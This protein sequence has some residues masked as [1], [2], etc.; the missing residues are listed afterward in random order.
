MLIP[1]GF[2]SYST[3]DDESSRGKLSQLRALLAGELQQHLGRAFKVNIFQD[4]AAIPPGRDWARQ[5]DE[6][7]EA[8]SFLI[9]IVTP[10]FLQSEWCCKE[11]EAFRHREER[12]GASGLIFPIHYIDTDHI[13]ATDPHECHD[14]SALEFLRARQW[15]DF[16]RLRLRHPDSED[17]ALRLEGLAQGIR[18][19]LR[20]P[21]A[22][23]TPSLPAASAAKPEKPA[24]EP[25]ASAAPP[26][27]EEIA[28]LRRRAEGSDAQ[29][30]F[31][32]GRKYETGQGIEKD[33]REAVAWYRKAAE[34]GHARAQFHLGVMYEH[35]RGVAKDEREAVAWYRKAAEQGYARAQFNL[36]VMHAKG[37]GVAKDEREAVAWYRK[38][39]EQGH[40]G[41]QCNLGVSYTKGQGVAEDAREAVA[42]YRKG[43]EQ[44]HAFAQ[45]NLGVMYEYGYGVTKDER[46]AVAWYR[47]AAEQG[48]AGAKE[49]LAKLGEG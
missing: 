16:R 2:W 36:G 48:Q 1:T 6:A 17:V 24:K 49:R 19:E 35:G 42:W 25:E 37:Q 29:A 3:S 41:A 46:E 31:D 15:V 11:V 8:S 43:A 30:Q 33:K 27:P 28:D 47:K 40:A 10:A 4:V 38:A 32:L 13:D 26:E 18:N 39:A 45:F 5:I 23:P 12:L 9:P 20:R 7:I 44:G 21:T 14:R 22:P 34:Q